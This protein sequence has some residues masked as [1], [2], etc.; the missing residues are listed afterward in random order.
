MDIFG[1][2]VPGEQRHLLKRGLR[3]AA[4]LCKHYGYVWV[5]LCC[6]GSAACFGPDWGNFRRCS[7]GLFSLS[8]PLNAATVWFNLLR[9]LFWLC[10]GY[11][12]LHRSRQ[13]RADGS[14]PWFF[15]GEHSSFGLWKAEVLHGKSWGSAC[16]RSCQAFLWGK[17]LL[18]LT[19]GGPSAAATC[20]GRRGAGQGCS[21]PACCP[22]GEPKG[23]PWSCLLGLLVVCQESRQNTF[24]INRGKLKK[25]VFHLTR[26]LLG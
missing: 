20:F 11:P 13:W 26:L 14:C 18:F 19:T 16:F 21:P 25:K 10:A 4:W 6:R 2:T 12:L 22:A 17:P 3:D 5:S 9:I 24:S 23:W 1:L 15:K 8:F 7:N